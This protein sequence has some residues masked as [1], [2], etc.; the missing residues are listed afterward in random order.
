MVAE[1]SVVSLCLSLRFI[2]GQLFTA[3]MRRCAN[4][5]HS[6]NG[7]GRAPRRAAW[8]GRSLRQLLGLVGLCR[9]GPQRPVMQA[10][11]RKIA[12]TGL[13]CRALPATLVETGISIGWKRVH[14]ISL[15]C[16]HYARDQMCCVSARSMY[17]SLMNL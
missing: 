10:S 8:M 12:S 7:A 15:P 11:H 4:L 1:V 6:C 2:G 17:G 3:S 13:L 14:V 16:A 9:L 5:N